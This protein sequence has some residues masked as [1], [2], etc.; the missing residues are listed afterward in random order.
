M[1]VRDESSAIRSWDKRAYGKR[2]AGADYPEVARSGPKRITKPTVSK[3]C[4]SNVSVGQRRKCIVSRLA[5]SRQA[6][7]NLAEY[8]LLHDLMHFGLLTCCPSTLSDRD[9]FPQADFIVTDRQG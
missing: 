9:H 2:S 3:A 4:L 6:V 7:Q 8:S 5:E 1:R